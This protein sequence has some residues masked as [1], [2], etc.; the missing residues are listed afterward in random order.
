MTLGGM[1]LGLNSS[2]RLVSC[3]NASYVVVAQS[4]A[5]QLVSIIVKQNLVNICRPAT[6]I[7]I[8]LV[9]ADASSSS[10]IQCYGFDVVNRAIRNQA[11]FLPTLVHRLAATDYSLQLNSMHLI[12][13]LFRHAT[14][15]ARTEFVHN[16]D[17][18]DTRRTVLRVMQSSP[19]EELSNQL[20]EFQRLLIQEG[21]R[22][23]RM[24]IDLKNVEHE[25]LLN[26]IFQLAEIEADAGVKWRRLGFDVCLKLF[27]C[28]AVKRLTLNVSRNSRDAILPEWD[29]WGCR[30]CTPL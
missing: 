30:P 6:A 20:V 11:S 25:R 10:P 23:K 1:R 14:P 5:L 24:P 29:Y 21:H 3:E 19:A 26:E 8:K 16:L 13:V 17:A 2:A 7:I 15:G 18:L 9:V 22:R 4:N 27:K 12:N 28:F